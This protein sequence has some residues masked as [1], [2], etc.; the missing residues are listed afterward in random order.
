MKVAIVGGGISGLYLAWK[1]SAKG[2]EATV[3]EKKE[4]IGKEVCSGLFSERILDYIPE[5]KKLIEKEIDYCLIHFPKK[6]VK[7]NFSQKFYLIDHFQLDNLVATLAEKAG[8][9]IFLNK[10]IDKEELKKMENNF[11]RIIGADGANSLLREYLNLPTP[12]IKFAI[13]GFLSEKSNKNFVE[14]W[15]TKSGFIWKIPRKKEIEWGIIEKKNLAKKIFDNF[16]K[17]NNIF[18][19]RKKSALLAQGF[20]IPKNKK[21]TLVG[22]SAGLTK[23][24]S[25]GGVIWG[26]I[27]CQILLKNFSDFVKYQKELKKFFLKKI[28]FSKIAKKMVY[29]FGFYLPFFLPKEA[30]IESDFLK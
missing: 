13:Q 30:K 7:I 22:E 26:L 25:G 19:E 4:K 29:F 16:L 1:L 21:I 24:W 23:P 15:P 3:F 27:S 18:L 14:V 17:K 12:A 9:K 5:S 6:T 28:I 2:E 11:D 20:I 8:A 10:K